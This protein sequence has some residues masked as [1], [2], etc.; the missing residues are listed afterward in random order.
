[1]NPAG[2]LQYTVS[3]TSSSIVTDSLDTLGRKPTRDTPHTAH[4]T[5]AE[6]LLR[7]H[8]PCNANG[9]GGSR[10][11]G[12]AAPT[13][14]AV[15]HIM[16]HI[17]AVVQMAPLPSTSHA[18]R[19]PG[20]VRFKWTHER[21]LYLNGLRLHLY[22]IEVSTVSLSVF[23]FVSDTPHSSAH[24]PQIWGTAAGLGTWA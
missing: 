17:T 20:R 6:R 23:C 1:M 9:G 22:A 16:V 3:H 2:P 7:A 15:A 14:S 5:Y 11:G 4:F 10:C 12:P 13:A 21:Q 24:R 8:H 18:C 19:S